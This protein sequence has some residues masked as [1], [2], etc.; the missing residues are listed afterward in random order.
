MPPSAMRAKSCAWRTAQLLVSDWH[1][2]LTLS[3]FS[4]TCRLRHVQN[5]T[6]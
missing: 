2:S 1:G 6:S 3:I 5:L 4:M